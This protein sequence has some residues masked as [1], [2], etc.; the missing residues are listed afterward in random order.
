M[1][2][3]RKLSGLQVFVNPPPPNC[4]PLVDACKYKRTPCIFVTRLSPV[5]KREL[6][7]RIKKNKPALAELLADPFV[8]ELQ[9]AFNAEIVI[10]E[11]QL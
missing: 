10:E 6:W 4:R 9:E 2:D 5:K 11:N 8:K 1:S 3:S 7:E